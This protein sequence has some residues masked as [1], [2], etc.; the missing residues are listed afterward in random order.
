M[1]LETRSFIPNTELGSGYRRITENG[2]W[3]ITDKDGNTVTGCQWDRIADPHDGIFAVKKDGKWGL[4]DKT[5]KPLVP[6]LYDVI[7]VPPAKRSHRCLWEPFKV[8]RDGKWGVLDLNGQVLIPCVWDDVDRWC[9]DLFGV[10]SGETW[11]A[12]NVKGTK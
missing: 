10:R 4:L 7:L 9:H 2:K 11:Q 8:K 12:V 1:D 5:G 3:G 6:C